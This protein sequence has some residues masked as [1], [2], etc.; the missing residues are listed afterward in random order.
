MSWATHQKR[1]FG[2]WHTYLGIIAGTFLAVVGMTGSI[3]VFR[4]EIDRSLNPDLFY[5]T[6]GT[7]RLPI[8]EV[9]ARYTA[10]PDAKKLSF[11]YQADTAANASF[12]GYS[13]E[14]QIFISAYS[15]K[16]LGE[17]NHDSSFIGFVTTLH[18]S[19]FIPGIGRY[20]NGLAALV[21]L[22][23]IISGLRLWL[24]KNKKQLKD[25]LAVKFNGSTKRQNYDWHRVIGLYSSPVVSVLALT[26]FCISFSLVI[27]PVLFILSLKNPM[28]A[29]KLLG[30]KSEYTAASNAVPLQ[31]IFDTA[32]ANIPLGTIR[33]IA[34]PADSTAAWR[35]DLTIPGIAD[36]PDREFVLIDQYSGKPLSNSA[37]DLPQIGKAY[38]TW[39]TPLHYGT[40]GGMATRI[41]A[42]IASLVPV[43][44]FITGLFIWLKRW[45][46][47]KGKEKSRTK[48]KEELA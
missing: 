8:D 11:L 27:I 46:K 36:E 17:R 10:Q 30:A 25:S 2:K 23:L 40:F 38:L 3:L 35:V 26:G 47:S 28:D 15:A 24:P 31:Q 37:T 33:G 18:R 19:F 41:L 20:L 13:G 43:A 9:Y 14:L 42:L 16:T 21:M 32:Q 5:A 12:I 34:P 48:K 7:E 22:I 45:K 39:L 44:L 4:D 29:A 6:D 1:W